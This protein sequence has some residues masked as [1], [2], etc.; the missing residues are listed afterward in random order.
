MT[1]SE[2][3]KSAVTA[4]AHPNI[5]LVK[6]WGKADGERNLPDVGSISITLDALATRTTV[7]LAESGDHFS[8]NESPEPAMSARLF[9]F[10]DHFYGADRPTLAVTSFNDFPTAAGLASS[11]SGFAALVVAVDALLHGGHSTPT[12]AQQAG[13]GSGSAARSL[14]GGFVRLDKPT[15]IDDDITVTELCAAADFPLEV[16]VAIT[17]EQR[18]TVGSTEGMRTSKQTSPFYPAWIETHE[19]DM[20]AAA[21]AIAQR[22]FERL[23][24]ISEH[25]CLKMHAVMQATRP[26]MLY[27]N[28][29]TVACMHAVHAL[30]A[31][32]TGV[33]FTIDA[34]PQVKAVC[35][36][37]HASAV[38]D[39]LASINGVQ[40]ILRTGLGKGARILSQ[41][42]N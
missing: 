37:E 19:A 24:N 11:A 28:S 20:A 27:W 13:R 25:S 9:G 42:P 1:A 16:V 12:L 5:A 21:G 2:P 14:F 36:P 22:D 10:L 33:F 18:K 39:E 31:S 23:A 30:R 35:L 15:G 6:Y 7:A 3:T 29:A 4:I 8:L 17:S 34:G 26:A 32:G 40:R 41:G 38:A